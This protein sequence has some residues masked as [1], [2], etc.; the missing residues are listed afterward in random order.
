MKLSNALSVCAFAA[1][2]NAQVVF[3]GNR[4]HYPDLTPRI[5]AATAET[6]YASASGTVRILVSKNNLPTAEIQNVQIAW[7]S[8]NGIQIEYTAV[9]LREQAFQ[10]TLL[11]NCSAMLS[12]YDLIILDTSF[13]PA[14]YNCSI[15]LLAYNDQL[16]AGIHRQMIYNSLVKNRLVSLPFS[17]S[18]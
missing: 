5:G 11:S 7:A 6:N 16:G 18:S 2:T 9:D 8:Q 15:D 13:A 10:K 3:N 12:T 4:T 14:F 1:L 17:I